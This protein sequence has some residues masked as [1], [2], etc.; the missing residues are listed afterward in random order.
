MEVVKRES[1]ACMTGRQREDK[2]MHV[3]EGGWATEGASL[4]LC[5]IMTET[6]MGVSTPPH[7]ESQPH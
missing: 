3:G 1:S 7:L 4:T 6:R 5:F 2:R